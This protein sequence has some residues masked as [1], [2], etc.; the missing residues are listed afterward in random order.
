MFN[1]RW[2]RGHSLWADYPD[3]GKDLFVRTQE[4]LVQRQ[5]TDEAKELPPEDLTVGDSVKRD[6]SVLTKVPITRSVM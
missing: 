6:G 5:L 1:G 3:I 2:S 4:V